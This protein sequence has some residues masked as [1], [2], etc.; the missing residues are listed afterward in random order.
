MRNRLFIR[1]IAMM[2]ILSCLYF[3]AGADTEAG[4]TSETSSPPARGYVV[5]STSTGTGFLPLPAEGEYT[6]PLRQL[7]PDGTEAVN[8]IHVTPE[9]V[10]MEDS[11]CANHDCVD[12]GPVTL[13]NREER[14]LWNMIICLP[15]QVVITLMTPEELLAQ[16]PAGAFEISAESTEAADGTESPAESTS[17]PEAAETTAAPD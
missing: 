2:L 17:A 14:L 11:T 3:P 13:E 12:Q 1:M 9:G 7:L 15:N 6:Y 4:G 5:I 16:V 8:W 10:W